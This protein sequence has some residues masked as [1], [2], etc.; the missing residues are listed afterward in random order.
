MSLPAAQILSKNDQLGD[1]HYVTS[2]TLGQT[3]LSL[4]EELN[5][6]HSPQ[7]RLHDA[8]NREEIIKVMSIN[9]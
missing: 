1:A 4:S 7:K 9:I 5:K 3:I 2:A 6:L 8:D